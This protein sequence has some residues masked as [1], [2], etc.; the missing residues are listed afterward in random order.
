MKAV[1]AAAMASPNGT[2][3]QSAVIITIAIVAVFVFMS[4]ASEEKRLFG[5]SE[6]DHFRI[7]EGHAHVNSLNSKANK[8]CSNVCNQRWETRLEVLN[9]L[10]HSE[11]ISSCMSK[12]RRRGS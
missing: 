3:N 9:L 10:D 7:G 6:K 2:S 11:L 5:F 12:Q 1:A 4:V 8:L